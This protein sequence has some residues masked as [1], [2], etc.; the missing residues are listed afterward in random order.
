MD[1]NTVCVATN[2]QS[3]NLPNIDV[4]NKYNDITDEVYVIQNGTNDD[5]GIIHTK[6]ILNI[7]TDELRYDTKNLHN[8]SKYSKEQ[9]WNF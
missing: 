6:Y 9:V 2:Y 1:G 4:L 8:S 5:F 3:C 7:K